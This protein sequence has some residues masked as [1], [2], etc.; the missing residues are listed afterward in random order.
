MQERL[1]STGITE[2]NG[3]GWHGRVLGMAWVSIHRV[4]Y[5]IHSELRCQFLTPFPLLSEKRKEEGTKKYQ[6]RG[7]DT[8]LNHSTL[9]QVAS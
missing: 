2:D 9:L 1:G 7:S 5:F 3:L 6:K 4:K 8:P